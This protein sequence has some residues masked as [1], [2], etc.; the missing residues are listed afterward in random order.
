MAD[1]NGGILL[2]PWM[3]G[4]FFTL[5]SVTIGW[6][7]SAEVRFATITSNRHTSQDQAVH[8]LWLDQ[9][10]RDEVPP[11]EVVQSLEDLRRRLDRLEMTP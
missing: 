9:K 1:L 5:L 6:V 11:P 4:V 7:I 3:V 10:F 8:L 2:R